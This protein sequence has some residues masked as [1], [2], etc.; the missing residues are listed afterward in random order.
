MSAG[1]INY[2]SIVLVCRQSGGANAVLTI[3][4][5]L[6]RRVDDRKEAERQA[7]VQRRAERATRPERG[8]DP[9]PLNVQRSVHRSRDKPDPDQVY[10]EAPTVLADFSGKRVFYSA[11]ALDVL[12]D[13]L[14]ASLAGMKDK[15]L[16]TMK[17]N[18]AKVGTSRPDGRIAVVKWPLLHPIAAAAIVPNASEVLKSP[19]CASTALYLYAFRWS[20]GLR[21]WL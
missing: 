3:P 8:H 21:R 5:Y 11:A 13:K 16:V 20:P 6:S 18:A 2:S 12:L 17:Q 7:Y 10:F 14:V 1:S 15:P 9:F 4:T 19:T